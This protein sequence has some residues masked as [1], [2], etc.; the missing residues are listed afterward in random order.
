M[1]GGPPDPWSGSSR[2]FVRWEAGL[3]DP[4]QHQ[5]QL[6][7]EVMRRDL[8]ILAGELVA[9]PEEDLWKVAG[10][11]RNPAGTLA[12]H[13]CGNL[14]HFIGAVLGETGYVRNREAEFAARGLDRDELL[15]QVEETRAMLASVLPG[16][17]PDRLHGPMP[18]VPPRYAGRSVGFFLIHLCSHLAYHLGQVNALRQILASGEEPGSP[19]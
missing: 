10:S 5:L 19:D 12:L 17:S 7:A 4:E 9:L 3:E 16:L 2:P 6:L 13:I 14:Q 18:G 1:T 11:A 8:E 15:V